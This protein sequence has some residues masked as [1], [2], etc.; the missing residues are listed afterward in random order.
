MS[1]NSRG[2]NIDLPVLGSSNDKSQRDRGASILT[3][4]AQFTG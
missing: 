1:K 2:A 3:G 4:P